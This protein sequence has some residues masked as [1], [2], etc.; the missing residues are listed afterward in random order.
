MNED[1][2][3]DLATE[4]YEDEYGG[5]CTR[6]GGWADGLDDEATYRA[7]EQWVCGPCNTTA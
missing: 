7:D 6:C 2:W 3:E 1:E 5:P 4:D